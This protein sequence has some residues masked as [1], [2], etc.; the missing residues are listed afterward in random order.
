MTATATALSPKIVHVSLMGTYVP[1]IYEIKPNNVK[2][3]FPYQQLTKIEG[4]SEYEKMCVVQEE[5]HRN[6]LSIK[7][8]FGGGKRGHKLLVTNP[9][10]YRI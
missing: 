7:P 2:L 1:V 8:S 3:R 4:E 6:S 5:I 10:I 9:K